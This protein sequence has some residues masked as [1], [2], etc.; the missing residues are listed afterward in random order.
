MSW[1]SVLAGFLVA[2]MVGD[3]LLQT[4]WQA[5]HPGD[6]R[7]HLR[8]AVLEK[9]RGNRLACTH[10]LQQALTRAQGQERA[11]ADEMLPAR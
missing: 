9:Q 2:H 1:V 11:G 10:A 6:H 5:R 4:D 3:Y 7:P 8:R